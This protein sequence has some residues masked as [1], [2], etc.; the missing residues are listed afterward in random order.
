VTLNT[1]GDNAALFRRN[2]VKPREVVA[3]ARR[4]ADKKR[5]GW[6][7]LDQRRYLP[8]DVLAKADRATMQ[9]SLEMRSPFLSRELAEFSAGIPAELHA[10]NGGKAVLRA[11]SHGMPGMGRK[12]RAKTAFRVPLAEWLRGPLAPLVDQLPADGRLV[13]DGWIEGAELRRLTAAHQSGEANHASAIWTV[14][15]ADLCL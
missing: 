1:K 14:L 10:S 13:R 15:A 12:S 7:R 3:C 4:V 9:L 5:G 8:D 2:I 11:V 6:Y